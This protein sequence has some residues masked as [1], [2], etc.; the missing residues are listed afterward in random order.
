MSYLTL[1]VEDG[2]I[3]MNSDG[4]LVMVE[5]LAQEYKVLL[6]TQYNSDYRDGEYGFR[7]YE[8]I[9]ADY[10]GDKEQLLRL[11]L[12]ECIFQHERTESIEEIIITKTSDRE[13]LAEISIK[14]KDTEELITVG[15]N[16]GV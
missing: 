15:A 4:Q 13:F 8:L 3:V 5:E 6:E 14:I 12:T 16:I 10:D 9:G 7:K 11:Y 2:D 1:L